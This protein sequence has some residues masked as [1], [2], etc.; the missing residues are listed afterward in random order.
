MAE[1]IRSIIINVPPEKFWSLITDFKVYPEFLSEIRKVTTSDAG[2]G[3]TDVSY[4]IELTLPVLNV[5]KTINY[6]LRFTPEPPKRLSW[7]LVK[8]DMKEN[9]GSWVLQGEGDGKTKATYTLEIGVG[10]LIPKVVT[11]VL[12][13]QQLPSMLDRFK[14][15]AESLP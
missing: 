4:T 10:L 13:E 9:R 11:T 15:R 5:T 8:G 2:G 3:K 7:S 14:K 12:A 6:T 1:A